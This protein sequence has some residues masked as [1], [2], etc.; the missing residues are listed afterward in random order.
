VKFLVSDE[1]KADLKDLGG[2]AAHLLFQDASKVFREAVAQTVR[3]IRSKGVG[4]FFVTQGPTDVPDDLGEVITSLGIS[5]AVVTVMDERG[6]PT[7]VAWTMLRAPESRMAPADQSVMDAVVAGSPLRA[8]YEE[9]IDRDSARERLAARLEQGSVVH[10][11]LSSPV[12]KDLARTAAK[13]IF[14]GVF[15]TAR[16]R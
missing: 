9:S 6:A 13:E 1:G 10:D 5:E 7:S 3:L 8:R 2:L 12:A 4:V 14:R 11:I 15:G 16:R